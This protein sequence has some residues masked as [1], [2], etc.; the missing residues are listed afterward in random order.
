[1]RGINSVDH[2]VSL[3]KITLKPIPGFSKSIKIASNFNTVMS[4]LRSSELR[5]SGISS[6]IKAHS[7]GVAEVSVKVKETT[8]VQLDHTLALVDKARNI[9][10]N[11][12]L[13][14][15]AAEETVEIS[16]KS[17]SEGNS[18]KL[19]MTTALGCISELGD[20]V[21]TTGGVI[22]KLGKNKDQIS[23]II[24]VIKSVVEQTNMLALNAAIEAARAGEQGRGFAVVAD[25]VRSLAGKTQDHAEEIGNVMDKLMVDVEN[26]GTH[27][28]KAVMLADQSDEAIESVVISYSEIVGYMK[29]VSAVGSQL[30]D[31][32]EL[33]KTNMKK[34]DE[35]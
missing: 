5:L 11:I 3:R 22:R 14:F 34:A 26:A 28:D 15:A 23:G 21:K 24:S 13:A 33:K 25:E 18:G 32:T 4:T 20:M 12:N 35:G 1:M 2:R 29:D 10:E 7:Q 6:Q 27:V 31:V 19:V 17:E 30:R 8:D 9:E 16:R